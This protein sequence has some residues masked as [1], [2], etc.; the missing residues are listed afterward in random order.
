M[1]LVPPPESET[2]FMPH[3]ARSLS[4]LGTWVFGTLCALKVTYFFHTFP[5]NFGSFYCDVTNAKQTTGNIVLTNTGPLYIFYIYNSFVFSLRKDQMNLC[6]HVRE[7]ARG[8]SM[9]T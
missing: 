6:G 1:G 4:F 2:A 8:W 5:L 3:A 7:S 9:T